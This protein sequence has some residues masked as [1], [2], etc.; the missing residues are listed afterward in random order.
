[1]RDA[2]ITI[3]IAGHETTALALAWGLSDIVPR[4][5]VVERL[6]DE[7]KKVNGEGPPE[8][9]HLRLPA[10]ATLIFWLV[11][12][13]T[14]AL[15]AILARIVDLRTATKPSFMRLILRWVSPFLLS[16]TCGVDYLWIALSRRK[17]AV[18]DVIAR[19]GVIH[20][21]EQIGSGERARPNSRVVPIYIAIA[22]AFRVKNSEGMR[23]TGSA[24]RATP[25]LRG[26][27]VGRD[28]GRMR[29]AGTPGMLGADGVGAIDGAAAGAGVV[30]AGTLYVVGV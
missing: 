2:I 6:T 12:S 27:D 16:Y 13:A 29:G 11:M 15:M 20:E 7:L 22:V 30:P 25:W 14:P 4:P 9:E 26:Q 1:V 19:T 18:H 24:S 10:F 17:Q 3:L 21:S 28:H 23:V 5:H 8:S